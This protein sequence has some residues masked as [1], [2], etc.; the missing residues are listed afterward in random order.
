LIHRIQPDSGFVQGHADDGVDFFKVGSGR[1]FGNH[2]PV[3]GVDGDLAMDLIRQTRIPSSTIPQE[4]SS[5]E[6]SMPRV[7]TEAR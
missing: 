7:T 3:F 5:Q 1:Y 6:V 4:V 2:A